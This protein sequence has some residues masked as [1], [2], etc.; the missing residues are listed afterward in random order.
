LVFGAI[1]A[2]ESANVMIDLGS[3]RSYISPTL[4]KKLDKQ[5]KKKA[6]PY[7]LIMADGIPVEYDDR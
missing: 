7:P 1:I 4:V 6:K 5:R 2:G 3:N